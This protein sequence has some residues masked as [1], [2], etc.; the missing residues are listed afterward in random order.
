MAFVFANHGKY[1]L[2]TTAFTGSTDVRCGVI[3]DA[4]VPTDAAIEDMDDVADLLAVATEAAVSGYSRQ[5]LAGLTVTED[6]TGNEVDISATAPNFGGANI[7]A[8][9]T[10]AGVFYYIE[11][12]TDADRV[13]IGVDKPASTLTTNGSTVTLPQFVA[14][15]S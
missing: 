8:G 13:L 11:A 2:L 10:W 15:L 3:T 9:E 14:T 5:D 6:D 12:A 1:Q 4:V 7:A